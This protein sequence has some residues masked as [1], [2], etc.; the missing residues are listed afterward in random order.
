MKAKLDDDLIPTLHDRYSDIYY[1]VILKIEPY[2]I[3]LNH[4]ADAMYDNGIHHGI[5]VDKNY[6]NS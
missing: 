2:G 1:N 6:T 3:S 4:V 5:S